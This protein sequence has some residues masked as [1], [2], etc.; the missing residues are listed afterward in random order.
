MKKLLLSVTALFSVL[1]TAQ[2]SWTTQNSAFP[3]AA[4]GFTSMAISSPTV[5]WGFG[6]DGSGGGAK[7]QTYTKTGNGG[8]SWSAGTIGI[9]N[10]TLLISDLYGVDGNTAYVIATKETGG[11]GGGIWKTTNGGSTW[12]KQTTASFNLSTSF[13]NVVVAFDANNAF[14]M[15]DPDS[16]NVF[17]LYTT[18]NGGTNWVRV[19]AGNIP[20]AVNEFGYTHIRAV[21]GN[22]VWFG[23]DNGRVFKSNDKGLNWTAEPTPIPDFGG[24]TISTSSGTITLKDANNAWIMDQDGSVWSTTDAGVNWTPTTSSPFSAEIAYVPGTTNTLVTVGALQTAYGSAISTDGGQTWTTIE[25]DN[26][27]M[28]VVAYNSSS[29]FAGGYNQSSTLDGAYKLNGLLATSDHNVKANAVSVYPNPTKG[30]VNLQS[31]VGIS[32]IELYDMSG[33]VVKTFGK[34]SQLDL[35]GLK[36][37]VYMLKVMTADGQSTTT[38]LIKN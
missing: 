16:S 17:E 12:T 28:T 26:Q 24:V 14:A 30:Q 18:S 38:K 34:I 11:S 31:K 29:V 8:T 7:Y 32:T 1:A 20:A 5:V 2:Y 15:G 37:G 36:S 10:T 27:K 21:A 13:P 3:I 9:G 6:Y 25:Q 33:K 22:T 4:T 35:S 23:T 19:P